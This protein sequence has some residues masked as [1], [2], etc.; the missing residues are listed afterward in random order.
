[1]INQTSDKE[2][3]YPEIYMPDLTSLTNTSHFTMLIAY[4]NLNFPNPEYHDS[5]WA[6]CWNTNKVLNWIIELSRAELDIE[7]MNS[8]NLEY[9]PENN[10]GNNIDLFHVVAINGVFIVFDDLLEAKAHIGSILT[11]EEYEH[12]SKTI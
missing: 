4:L 12:F 8:M 10:V 11:F 3:N 5:D 2:C 6:P 9:T 7:T 1:M